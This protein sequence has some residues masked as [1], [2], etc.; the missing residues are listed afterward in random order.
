MES[1]I[2]IPSR[3][4][5]WSLANE[6]PASSLPGEGDAL[7]CR[8]VAERTRGRLAIRAVADGGLGYK[9]R[10]QLLAVAEGRIAMAD[11]FSGALGEVE[12][13]F[14]L[15][16]LPFTVS[17]VGEAR[18]LYDA[19]RPAYEA[20]FARH[21]QRLLFAT[22]WPP[23][24]LW[25][26]V[27]VESPK[28]IAALKV[29]TYDETGARIFRG[30]GAQASVV[31]FAELAPRIAAG[32]IDAVLSSGDGGAGRALWDHFPRFTAIAYAMPLSFVT[33]N[34]DRCNELDDAMRDAVESAARE[35][36]ARQWRALEGR[37]G[38][39]YARMREHGVTIAEISGALRERLRE[40]AGAL[41]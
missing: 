4:E 11:T 27:P 36:E 5:P 34:I 21:R 28:D 40:T 35:T 24:G 2:E 23:S 15:S 13:V 30:L 16:A 41:R 29:R 39:N 19:M 9:S 26:R 10:D 33:L 18:A 31:S 6:Y 17:G 12:A 3:V 8:L 1:A 22:P 32:D 20:A 14:A 38:E 7:F 37:I 25:T